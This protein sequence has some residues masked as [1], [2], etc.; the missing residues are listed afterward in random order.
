MVLVRGPKPIWI[1]DRD[2]F[3]SSAEQ[4]ISRN[5][6]DCDDMFV[7]IYLRALDLAFQIE[8]KRFLLWS[9]YGYGSMI[10]MFERGK[11]CVVGFLHDGKIRIKTARKRSQSVGMNR[12]L[13]DCT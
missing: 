2:G 9:M 13:L 7:G 10:E 1:N 6:L 3:T 4:S 5:I 11:E 8:L 12:E